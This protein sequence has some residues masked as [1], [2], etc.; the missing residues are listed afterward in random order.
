[1]KRQ[2]VFLLVV[3][4]LALILIFNW[5]KLS[6]FIRP[7]AAN[8]PAPAP[9]GSSSTGSSSVSYTPT[10]STTTNPNALLKKGS[11][12]ASVKELQRMMIDGWGASILPQYGADGNF[13]DETE[14]ALIQITG[15]AAT[16]L[17]NFRA[18]FYVKKKT[19]SDASASADAASDSLWDFFWK[20]ATGN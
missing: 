14:A 11:A 3:V 16:T 13:G 10:G 12:G 15:S 4:V 18:N 2:T 19:G 7:K 5:N 8:H 17:P 6:A 9:D 1:M 20:G